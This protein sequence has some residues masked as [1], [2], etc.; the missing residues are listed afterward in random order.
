MCI[1]I[2]LLQKCGCSTNLTTIKVFIYL[3][4]YLFFYSFNFGNSMATIEFFILF[5]YFF[6]SST[7]GKMLEI[8]TFLQNTFINC[9]CDESLLINKKMV[10]LVGTNENGKK[11]VITTVCKKYGKIVCG[12]SLLLSQFLFYFILFYF[13]LIFQFQQFNCHNSIFLFFFYFWQYY[14]RNSFFSLPH[15]S[16]HFSFLSPTFS[17]NF[18]NVVAKIHFSHH[19]AK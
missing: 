15:P 18:G 1:S 7:F 4:I 9:W 5:I 14:C 13:F 19:F 17:Q 8:Q 11:L 6:K 3:F 10:L 16:H 12:R 2:I